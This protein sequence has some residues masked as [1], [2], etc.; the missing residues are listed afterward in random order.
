MYVKDEYRKHPLS[1]QP[2]GHNVHVVFEDGFEQI[3]DKVKFPDKFIS[4]IKDSNNRGKK[5]SSVF[6]DGKSY[7]LR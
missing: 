5:I 1:F 7:K 4:K 2:G 6:V 3:Y